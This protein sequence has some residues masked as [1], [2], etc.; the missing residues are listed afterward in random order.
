M[1]E[2]S[3][4]V[5][6][7]FCHFYFW[8]K[9]VGFSKSS[10]QGDPDSHFWW[11]TTNMWW[12]LWILGNFFANFLFV[13]GEMQ[14]LFNNSNSISKHT[15]PTFHESLQIGTFILK[16]AKRSLKE[17]VFKNPTKSR[18]TFWMV[19]FYEFLKT[20]S[21]RSNSVTRQV[22]LNRTKIEK[23]K[24]DILGDFQRLCSTCLTLR[25][26]GDVFDT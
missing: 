26:A 23:L 21:L 24:C 4:N 22:S 20:C 13:E 15:P 7:Q 18:I 8:R 10:I 11:R 6:F 25:E 3:Q 16:C 19:H 14:N 2:I 12:H 9:N 17:T 5:A 1:F